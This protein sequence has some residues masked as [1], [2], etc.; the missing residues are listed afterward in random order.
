MI[1]K[2]GDFTLLLKNLKLLNDYEATIR[3]EEPF[4]FTDLFEIP[5]TEHLYLCSS[6]RWVRSTVMISLYTHIIRC[7]YQYEHAA[8]TSLISWRNAPIILEM[9]RNTR[10]LSTRLIWI[11]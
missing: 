9:Q 7:L 2:G 6:S 3:E 10:N 8:K 4:E 1:L 11:C 5:G